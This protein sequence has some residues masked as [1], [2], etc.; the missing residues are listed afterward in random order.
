[1]ATFFVLVNVETGEEKQA[2]KAILDLSLVNRVIKVEFCYDLIV[3][4]S[5]TVEAVRETICWAIG[6]TVGVRSTLTLATFSS[7]E[8][9]I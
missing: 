1:M 9:T 6:K 3:E 8:K 2:A 5:G 4:I 7:W